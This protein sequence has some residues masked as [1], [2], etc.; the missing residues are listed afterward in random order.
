MVTAAKAIP[1]FF[2]SYLAINVVIG[3]NK[4]ALDAINET[5]LFW[6][7]N[8]EALQTVFFIVLVRIFDQKSNH[9][10]DRLIG[11]AQKHP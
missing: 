1:L 11:I 6:A 9:N 2:Y 5:P 8:L 4:K 3:D 10:I 7:T